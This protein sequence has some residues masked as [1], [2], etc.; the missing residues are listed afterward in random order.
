NYLALN[1]PFFGENAP[2]AKI[3]EYA[4]ARV[5][6]AN[7]ALHK[8]WNLTQERVLQHYKN[9]RWL[10]LVFSISDGINEEITPEQQPKLRSLLEPGSGL[11]LQPAYMRIYPKGAFASH[12]IGYT[13]RTRPLPTGPIQDGDT[14]FDEQEGLE[15]LE[16]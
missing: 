7:R 8:S 15:G 11:M 14:L 1:F 5:R 6:G 13:H 2:D 3:L 4:A 10:P 12:I 16:K 9:R